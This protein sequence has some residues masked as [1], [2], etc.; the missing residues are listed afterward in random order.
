MLTRTELAW[1]REAAEAGF[2]ATPG[3]TLDLLAL[4]D[5]SP[6]PS[7]FQ[8]AMARHGYNP[9]S[10]AEALGCTRGHVARVLAGQRRLGP[11]LQR[12]AVALGFAPDD[13]DA[14]P[15]GIVGDPEAL[16][17]ALLTAAR[18]QLGVPAST[19]AV[20]VVE[21]VLR[22]LARGLLRLAPAHVRLHPAAPYD[23]D[24]PLPWPDTPEA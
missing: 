9:V 16:A 19:P 15:A 22:T 10:L 4:L 23:Y 24:E 14:A 18:Q 12:K 2:H 21:A 13:L 1:L 5:A 20:V 3:T 8:A 7:P 6:P 11:R 17:A